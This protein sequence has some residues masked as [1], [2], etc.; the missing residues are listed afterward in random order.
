MNIIVTDTNASE[1]YVQ[2]NKLI[3]KE[4]KRR[5]LKAILYWV[6]TAIIF[7]IFDIVFFKTLEFGIIF[8]TLAVIH[9]LAMNKSIHKLELDRYTSLKR[10]FSNMNTE[11]FTI[12]P[13]TITQE[14]EY[15]KEELNWKIISKYLIISN[16]I[17]LGTYSKFILIIDKNF[18]EESEF[19]QFTLFL[20]TNKPESKNIYDLTE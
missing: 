16:F 7:T 20:K 4:L 6:T 19:D 9:F 13:N 11:T 17:I 12:G 10:H 3:L 1:K 2:V 15:L 8:W 14:R 5:S 18:M